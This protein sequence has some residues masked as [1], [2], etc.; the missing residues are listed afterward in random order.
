MLR[1]YRM[2][3]GVS[4]DEL[5]NRARVSAET[6][7]ALERRT[8]RAPYRETVLRLAEALELSTSQRT[9]L[10]EAAARARRGRANGNVPHS[11]PSFVGRDAEMQAL[12]ALARRHRLITITGLGGIG[13]TR[14]AIELAT[15]I[16]STFAHGTWLVDLKALAGGDSV[17]AKIA[18]T[19]GLADDETIAD[20]NLARWLKSRQLLLV[21]DHCDHLLDAVADTVTHLLR[22]CPEL[23]IVVASRAR[24]A[25]SGETVFRLEPLE[26]S[27]TG[28]NETVASG[29]S[30]TT[31]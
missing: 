9:A 1:R 6:I 15:R 26:S 10:E 2:A 14:T 8:R 18:T 24:L 7:G 20:R 22:A 23:R 12:R 11:L 21:L 4:Q 5:G 30:Q 3:A 17:A 31:R 27:P 16:A 25:L 19:I 28:P 13:K 29:D